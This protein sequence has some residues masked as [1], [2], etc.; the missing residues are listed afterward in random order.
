MR[1]QNTKSNEWQNFSIV[2]TEDGKI[3][4]KEQDKPICQSCGK[5]VLAKGS[6]TIN[7]FQHWGEHHPLIKQATLAKTIAR[8]ANYLLDST[9]VKAL[10]HAVTYY[11]TKDSVPI[12]TVDSSIWYQSL[13][14]VTRYHQGGTL[15]VLKFLDCILTSKIT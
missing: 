13:I 10:N 6:N 8:S 2:S 5:G 15:Q 4:E 9:G 12:S 7:L 1:K 14:H 11:I 3:I